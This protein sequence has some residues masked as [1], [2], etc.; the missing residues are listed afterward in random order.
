MYPQLSRYAFDMYALP[1][2]S[3]E[4][5]RTLCMAG[6]LIN[7][8]RNK[9]GEDNIEVDECLASRITLEVWYWRQIFVLL[10]HVLFIRSI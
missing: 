3:V 1:A 8:H 10:L 2:L 4:R 6:N 5:E 7:S 9:L